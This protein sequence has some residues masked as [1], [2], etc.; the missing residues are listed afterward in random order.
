MAKKDIK[1]V[2]LDDLKAMR[3][4][5][6]LYHNPNAPEG[7]DLGADFWASAEVVNPAEKKSIHLRVDSDVLEFFKSRGKGHL[8]RMNAVLRRYMEA[9]NRL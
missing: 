2:S 9:Q 5:G 8:T 3:E 6:K 7:E 1:T 4:A